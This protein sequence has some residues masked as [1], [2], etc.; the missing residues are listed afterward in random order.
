MSLIVRPN[1]PKDYAVFRPYGENKASIVFEGTE[2]QCYKELPRLRKQE[3]FESILAD[4]DINVYSCDYTENSGYA[5]QVGFCSNAGE[6]FTFDLNGETIED[7][8][9]D[10]QH[11]SFE[12]DANEHAKEW[13]SYCGDNGVPNDLQVLIDDANEIKK[14]L[15]ELEKKVRDLI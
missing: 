4:K 15:E 8:V 5:Y 6:D 9:K 1:Y 11:Y 13:V 10:L 12:F 14:R 2:E 7:V 3:K